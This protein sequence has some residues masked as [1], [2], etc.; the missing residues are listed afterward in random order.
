[1]AVDGAGNVY[2]VDR[3]NDDIRKITPAGVVTTLAGVPGSGGS[4]D[5][6][7]AAAQ[8]YAPEGLAVDSSGNIY[9]S[10]YF[11]NAVR[12]IAPVG[13][14]WIVTTLAGCPTCPGGTNDGPGMTARFNNAFGLTRDHNGNLYVAD[15]V[16]KTI[17]KI[18]PSQSEWVVTTFAGA[19]LQGGSLDGTGS[20]TRFASPLGLAADANGIYVA[21]AS[22]VRKITFDGVV[23]TLAGCPTCPPGAADGTGNAA[24][25]WSA[26]GVAVDGAGD[27]YVAD[28]T[29]NHLVRKVTSSGSDWM[30]TTLGGSPGQ[31]SSAD[32]V[33]SEARFNQ[34]SGVAVDSAGN[35]YVVDAGANRITKG[36]PAVP[37]SPL[38]FATSPG[39]LSVSNGAFQMRFRNSSGSNLVVVLEASANLQNW[40]PIQTN[41]VS[42]SGFD[43]S[44]LVGTNQHQFFRARLG[45]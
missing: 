39:S 22:T 12:K 1:V 18:S 34:P 20:S 28:S 8:F 7:G 21:D 36:T 24:R 43:L 38:Q 16:N 10:D 29:P 3:S 4:T 33:G 23:T 6:K 40:T 2:A 26:R 41:T 30:V 32:G 19:P 35:I 37:Q 42:P 27:L 13:T 25:F 44:V 9:V 31:A 11:N 15:T 17:R 5:G 45:P 14:N